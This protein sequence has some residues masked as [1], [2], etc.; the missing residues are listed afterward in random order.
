MNINKFFSVFLIVTTVV[1]LIGC[2]PKEEQILQG[3]GNV[4]TLD[5]ELNDLHFNSVVLKNNLDKYFHHNINI[6]HDDIFN[7]KITTDSNIHDFFAI[8]VENYNLI[9]A[10]S[11]FLVKFGYDNINATEL[12]IDVYI[13]EIKKIELNGIGNIEIHDGNIYDF[14]IVLAGIG[15]V[16]LQNFEAVNVNIVLSGTGNI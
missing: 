1:F 2:L 15:N 13:P 12:I 7:V 4:I 6:Y 14:E 3:N 8:Y 9:I 11:Y 10:H 16:Y 5:I